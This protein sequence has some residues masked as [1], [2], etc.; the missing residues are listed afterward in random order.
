MGTDR[1]VQASMELRFLGKEQTCQADTG[2]RGLLKETL[3]EA[4]GTEAQRLQEGLLL[5]RVS[6]NFFWEHVNAPVRRH[7]CQQRKGSTGV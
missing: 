4:S 3:E 6:C 1:V 7:Q 5:T 2:A